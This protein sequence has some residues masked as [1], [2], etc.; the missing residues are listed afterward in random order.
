MEFFVLLA[1]GTA[2]MFFVMLFCGKRY[3]ISW[4]KASVLTLSLTVSG[5]LGTKFMFFLETNAWGGLS[6]FGAVF[7]APIIMLLAALILRVPFRT[8]LDLCAPAECIMLSVMKVNCL[9]YGCCSG[10]VIFYTDDF[11]PVFFP[12]QLVELLNAIIL[13]FV[14]F[15]IMH[16]ERNRGKIYPWYMILYGATRFVLN[17]LRDTD[18]FVLGIPAGHIWSIVSI[19]GGIIWI[20]LFSIY[21]KK[22]TFKAELE[23]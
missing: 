11:Y 7:F 19:F 17:F 10:R 6:F 9:R 14:L 18:P 16:Y 21:Y 8:V 2:F 23:E 22:K 3:K 12:S 13:M 15:A 5:V 20:C 4:L 1:V